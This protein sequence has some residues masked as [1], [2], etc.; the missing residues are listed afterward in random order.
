M[1][2][3]KII[4]VIIILI[5]ISFFINSYTK[6]E[7]FR[8]DFEFAKNAARKMRDFLN[9]RFDFKNVESTKITY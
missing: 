7:G 1:N 3:K 2:F 8:E 5:L 4:A 6:V 9:T